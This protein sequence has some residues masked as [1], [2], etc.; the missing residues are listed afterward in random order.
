MKSK[1]IIERSPHAFKRGILLSMRFKLSCRVGGSGWQS[2]EAAV[3]MHP[4]HVK[5]RETAADVSSELHTL[6]C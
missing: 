5:R 4:H 6:L 3:L 2:A 1:Y